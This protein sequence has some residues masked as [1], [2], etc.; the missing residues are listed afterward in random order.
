MWVGAAPSGT[1]RPQRPGRGV[2]ADAGRNR[3]R[4][5]HKSE[6]VLGYEKAVKLQISS[7]YEGTWGKKGSYV[8]VTGILTVT[9]KMNTKL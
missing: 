1:D 8:E 7:Q 6:I 5:P 9:V 3:A 4:R 2:G